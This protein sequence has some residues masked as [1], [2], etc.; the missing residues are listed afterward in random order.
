MTALAERLR[1]E[2]DSITQRQDRFGRTVPFDTFYFHL[3][4]YTLLAHRKEDCMSK[5][6]LYL[7]QDTY[8]SAVLETDDGLMPTRIYEA[9]AAIEQRLLSPIEAESEEHKAIE[10]A[11]RALLALK[12]ERAEF[13][14]TSKPLRDGGARESA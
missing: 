5:P 3:T 14:G 7:W 9:L 10:N 8:M 2:L 12:V 11:Q 4:A 6:I 13:K 1:F